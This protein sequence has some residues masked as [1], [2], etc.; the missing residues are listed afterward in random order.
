MRKRIY[1]HPFRAFMHG[2]QIGEYRSLEGASTA[3]KLRFEREGLSAA[4]TE[5]LKD[6]IIAGKL[7]T[8]SVAQEDL[9]KGAA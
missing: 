5:I 9:M 4:Y 6:E 8:T 2:H 3:I 1:S 7:H